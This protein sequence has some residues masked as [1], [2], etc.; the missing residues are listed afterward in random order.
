MA[1]REYQLENSEK[2]F[3][4]TVF[5]YNTAPGQSESS[6]AQRYKRFMVKEIDTEARI[7]IRTLVRLLKVE[8]ASTL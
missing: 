6:R 7:R 1:A 4:R 8:E 2:D 3:L 5:G